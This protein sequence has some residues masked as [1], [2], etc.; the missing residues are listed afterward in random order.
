[1]D[2]LKT[3]ISFPC[4]N[5]ILALKIVGDTIGVSIKESKQGKDFD[6]E[7]SI[8]EFIDM[9]SFL[10]HVRPVAKLAGVEFQELIS[11]LPTLI[12]KKQ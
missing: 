6:T 8:S 12:N 5:G 4:S 1:M 10:Y 11:I 9:F 7:L 3:E 2:D